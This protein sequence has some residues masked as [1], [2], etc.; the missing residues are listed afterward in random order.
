MKDIF[1]TNKTM[2]QLLILLFLFAG[3]NI[4]NA[5]FAENNAIY[6]SG[7]MGAGNYFNGDLNLNYVYKENYSLKIGYSG[8]MRKAKSRPD[9]YYSGL[10]KGVF[11]LGLAN[12]KDQLESYHIS[13]GKILYLN[14]SKNIRANL[15]FGVG[16]TTITEPENWNK[17]EGSVIGKIILDNYTWDYGK[18]HVVIFIINPK[19]EFPITRYW[20][21]TVSPMVQFN[22]DRTYFGIG[23]GSMLGLLK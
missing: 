22:K 17:V 10:V 9:D 16:Y 1:K 12:P 6:L 13:F 23:I 15:L 4:V 11:M 3:A 8:N 21:L 19:I 18:R 2:K 14:T 20:G 5:Q 7:E